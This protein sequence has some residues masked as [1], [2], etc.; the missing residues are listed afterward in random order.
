MF[1]VKKSRIIVTDTKEA[2][3]NTKPIIEGRETKF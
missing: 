3:D 1:G 2:I